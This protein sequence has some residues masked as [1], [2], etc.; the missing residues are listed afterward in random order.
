[1]REDP[2]CADEAAAAT[3]WAQASEGDRVGWIAKSQEDVGSALDWLKVRGGRSQ[4]GSGAG[5]HERGGWSPDGGGGDGIVGT[6][7]C[8]STLPPPSARLPQLEGY[9][10]RLP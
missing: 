7:S 6:K 2:D 5:A 10:A 1:V 8:H 9:S 3:K 4:D